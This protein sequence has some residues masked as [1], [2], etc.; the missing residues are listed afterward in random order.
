[1]GPNTQNASE[2]HV[3]PDNRFLL[4]SLRD[5]NS[6]TIPSPLNSSQMITSDS[7]LS[8]EIDAMTGKVDLVQEAPAGGATPRQFALN[9]KGDLVAVAVQNDGWVVVLERDC[10]SGKVG[11]PVGVVGGLGKGAQTGVVCVIWDQ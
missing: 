7:L 10:V 4:A 5:D 11:G 9:K 6:F 8:Y 3:S 1:M 2:L